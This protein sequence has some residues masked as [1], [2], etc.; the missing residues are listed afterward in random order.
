[1][2]GVRDGVE[3]G[4]AMKR[5]PHDEAVDI[6]IAHALKLFTGAEAKLE[7]D[8]SV[9]AMVA[10]LIEVAR[11]FNYANRA[12]EIAEECD[13]CDAEDDLYCA[14]HA[15]L[16]RELQAARDALFAAVYAIGQPTE[17]K[18]RKIPVT[19]KI[20]ERLTNGDYLRA[21]GNAKCERCER[22]YIEH[23]V[24]DTPNGGWWAVACDGRILK[25]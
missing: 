3:H 7:G 6:A 2:H 24:L 18:R 8:A 11:E 21:G 12:I 4:D 19:P 13:D 25:L 1:M 16:R 9:V 15:W 5:V 14:E 17:P 23:D 20:H 10:A 22:T